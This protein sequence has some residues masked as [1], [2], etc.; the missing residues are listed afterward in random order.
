MSVDDLVMLSLK[1][2]K[3]KNSTTQRTGLRVTNKNFK[4][5]K[6]ALKNMC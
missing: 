4:R 1:V 2:K 5:K 6:N 3:K